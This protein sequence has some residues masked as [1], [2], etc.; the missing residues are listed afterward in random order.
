VA[1]LRHGKTNVPVSLAFHT[2]SFSLSRSGSTTGRSP[3]PSPAIRGLPRASGATHRPFASLPGYPA[4][5][6][7]ANASRVSLVPSVEQR[8]AIVHAYN[9]VAGGAEVQFL[10]RQISKLNPDRS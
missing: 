10:I 3:V 1:L 5:S 4:P 2:N 9:V 8:R 7:N 6:T